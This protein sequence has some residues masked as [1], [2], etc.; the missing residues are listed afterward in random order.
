[1]DHGHNDVFPVICFNGNYSLYFYNLR[2]LPEPPYPIILYFRH[3]TESITSSCS[4]HSRANFVLPG[5]MPTRW[6]HGC[7]RQQH[8]ERVVFWPI[9]AWT[10]RAGSLCVCRVCT[11]MHARFGLK[12]GGGSCGRFTDQLDGEHSVAAGSPTS[13][14]HP[15]SYRQPTQRRRNGVAL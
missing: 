10:P 14:D 7:I 1:M 3:R 15:S 4:L 13:H 9:S 12:R 6:V 2:S 5:I 11:C 8:F